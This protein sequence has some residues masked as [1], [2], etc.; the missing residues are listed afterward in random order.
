MAAAISVRT[1]SPT[2]HLAGDSSGLSPSLDPRIKHALGQRLPPFEGLSSVVGWGGEPPGGRD[3]HPT[4][5][6]G[7]AFSFALGVAN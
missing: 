3:R 2:G 7:P 5:G 1:G 4:P 6:L